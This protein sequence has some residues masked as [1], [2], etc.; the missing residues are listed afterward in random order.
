MFILFISIKVPDG[1]Q[2]IKIHH[3]MQ[4]KSLNAPVL[5][6]KFNAD[7][8]RLLKVEAIKLNL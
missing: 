8:E 5:T 7:A 2:A 3:I 4:S 6:L 1:L